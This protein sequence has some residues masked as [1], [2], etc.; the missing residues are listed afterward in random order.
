H[1]QPYVLFAT[2]ADHR[3]MVTGVQRHAFGHLRDA[4]IARRAIEPV[5]QRTG[6]KRPGEGVLTST[7]SDEKYVHASRHPRLVLAPTTGPVM[8]HC[9]MDRQVRDCVP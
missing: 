4:T 5:Q 9:G 7:R 3:C 1:N 8:Y 6:E 2:E